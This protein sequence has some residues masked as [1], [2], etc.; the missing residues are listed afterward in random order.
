MKNSPFYPSPS[1]SF[2]KQPFLPISMNLSKDTLYTHTTHSHSSTYILILI[3]PVLAYIPYIHIYTY[4]VHKDTLY[5]HTTHSHSST[6]ILI[7]IAPV[8]RTY[9][10]VPLFSLHLRICPGDCPTS[11]HGELPHSLKAGLWTWPV[12]CWCP[13]GYSSLSY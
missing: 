1:A 12:P 3:A 5:T 11:V 7:L 13:L 10:S 6:Y 9:C 2:P 4:R 8:C